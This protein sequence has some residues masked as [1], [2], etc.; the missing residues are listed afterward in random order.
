[1]YTAC[2]QS[3]HLFRKKAEARPPFAFQRIS[4]A[5]S[6]CG[7]QTNHFRIRAIST[8]PQITLCG[9]RK[10]CLSPSSLSGPTE[11]P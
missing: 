9:K 1:M 2:Q 3:V 5:P 6:M 4:P 7:H 8:C 10:C 11:H